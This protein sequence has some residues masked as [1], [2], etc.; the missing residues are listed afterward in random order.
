MSY[1]M[2]EIT[3]FF[4]NSP[5]KINAG[6]AKIKLA[7]SVHVDVIKWKYFPRYWPFVRGIHRSPTDSPH[8]GQ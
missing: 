1:S 6:S 3:P 8:K 5:L 7:S 4:A 2:K